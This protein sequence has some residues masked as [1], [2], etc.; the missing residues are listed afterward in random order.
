MDSYVVRIYRRDA[1]NPHNITGSVEVVASEDHT[2]KTF[3][4]FNELRNIL[5]VTN[6][7]CGS[8]RFSAEQKKK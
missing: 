5:S 7:R 2:E 3:T 8:E 4:D 1:Q 6:E